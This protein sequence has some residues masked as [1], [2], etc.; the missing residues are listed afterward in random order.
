MNNSEIQCGSRTDIG[1]VRPHNEDSLVVLPPLFA[2]A[3]GMGGHEAGEVASEIAIETLVAQAAEQIDVRNLGRAVTAAN[4]AVIRSAQNGMGKPG[5]GT[6]MTAAAIDGFKL[7]IAHV[8]DSRAYLLHEGILQQITHDHSLVAELVSSGEITAEEARWHPQ[9]SVITRA[10]GSDIDMVP[11][12]YELRMSP[13][14]R[15]L[16]CSDGLSGMVTDD[17]LQNILTENGDPQKAADILID[18]ANA[19]GGHD[20]ITAIVVNISPTA[21]D[22]G[23]KKKPHSS[24]AL[25]WGFVAALV[26][27]VIAACIGIYAYA[28]NSIYLKAQDGY[29]AVYRGF[30]DTVAGFSLSWFE[31][32]SNVAISDL[33]KT[34]ELSKVASSLQEGVSVGSIEEADALIEEYQKEI[35]ALKKSIPSSSSSTANGGSSANNTGSSTGTDVNTES[36]SGGSSNTTTVSDKGLSTTRAV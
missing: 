14:D 26:V 29:V 18:T 2:V 5:M 6:T 24:K 9:R 33:D 12:L 7:V 23:Q 28:R 25:L 34:N 30:P 10:L 16:L 31:K 15:L 13:G 32:G 4:R 11:D 1:K 3:D 35:L 17:E 22:G 21:E 8:G 20:N 27:I 19:N 36:G